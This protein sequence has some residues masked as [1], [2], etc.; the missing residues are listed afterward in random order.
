MDTILSI[1]VAAENSM[2]IDAETGTRPIQPLPEPGSPADKRRCQ[3]RDQARWDQAAGD[4][5]AK[6]VWGE[7]V[8]RRV[9]ISGM[10]LVVIN[11]RVAFCEDSAMKTIGLLGHGANGEVWSKV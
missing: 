9:G 6:Q 1:M 8:T 3:H 2:E 5:R 7:A 11:D 10:S 4:A